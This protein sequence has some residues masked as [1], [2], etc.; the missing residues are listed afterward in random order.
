MDYRS[1]AAFSGSWGRLPTPISI[2][3]GNIGYPV[4]DPSFAEPFSPVASRGSDL[5]RLNPPSA[6]QGLNPVTPVPE[7]LLNP[8][9]IRIGITTASVF[10][11]SGGVIREGDSSSWKEKRISFSPI[12]LIASSRYR[13]LNPIESG[14]PA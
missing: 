10:S 7:M 12:A 2:S 8:C 1:L 13:A 11:S 3:W 4:L 14:S 5:P 9:Q 6:E